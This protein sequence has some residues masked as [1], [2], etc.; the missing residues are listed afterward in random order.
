MG[1]L[2]PNYITCY[3]LLVN[4]MN[5]TETTNTTDR[6]IILRY[7]LGWVGMVF[8]AIFN[9]ILRGVAFEPYVA[10]QTAH[11][12]SCVTGVSLFLI[13]TW[14]YNSKWPIGSSKQALLIGLMWLILTPIFEFGFGLYVMGH[15]LEHLLNDYNLLAGRAWTLV[16]VAVF[17]L[18]TLVYR[19]GREKK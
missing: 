9:G 17:L 14:F 18:P 4:E 15:P 11:L 8:I 19:I 13:A 1:N 3:L 5:Q 16:L 7:L 2:L 10:E 12:I 6:D